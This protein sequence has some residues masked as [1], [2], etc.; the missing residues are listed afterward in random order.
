[1][2]KNTI[3]SGLIQAPMAG[4]QNSQMALEVCRA[5]GM[6]SI[7]AA[8]LSLEALEKEFVAMQAASAPYNVNF[9]A[10]QMPEPNAQRQEQWQALLQPYFE[11]F[12][13]DPKNLPPAVQRMPFAQAQLEL[14]Q[15]Y[16]PAVVSFHFGL[17]NESLVQAVKDTGALVVSS[18]TTVAEAVYL[19]E[20]GV[21]G[22]IAQ[23][24]EAGG[25]RGLFLGV[26]PGTTKNVTNIAEQVGTFALLPQVLEAVS[27]YNITL[28]AAGGLACSAS[29]AAAKALGAD[30]VQLGTSYLLCP[31]SLISPRHRAALL[32]AKADPS[33]H[34]TAL[35]NLFTG[36][37]ARSLTMGIMR[38]LNYIH[39]QVNEF[40]YAGQEMAALKSAAE[41]QGIVDFSSMWSGQNLGACAEIPA[42]DL[43]REL[44]EQWYANM[45]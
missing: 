39:D 29:F 15:Q 7:P 10:H 43:T 6:G 34:V 14:V 18:A 9:F 8:M 26:E 23:G 45:A 24:S 33:Q 17:P 11:R 16:R 3:L 31:E 44:L 20:R 41:A 2:S 13:I 32:A 5:G 25:H 12:G 35:S 4:A 1:M 37:P 40:P 19:A 42:Y 21:D 27:K 38:D 28:I 36:K 22:V 30:A